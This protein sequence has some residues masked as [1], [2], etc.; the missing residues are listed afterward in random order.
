MKII[1]KESQ[2]KKIF[3][4]GK[5][6]NILEEQLTN[7]ID[8][9]IDGL[10]KVTLVNKYL[11]SGNAA[12]E[13]QTNFPRR[14]IDQLK[15]K[16]SLGSI[17]NIDQ[18]IKEIEN[19]STVDGDTFKLLYKIKEP[20][21]KKSLEKA[22]VKNNE[23]NRILNLYNKAESMG[24]NDIKIEIRKKLKE[25]LGDSDSDLDNFLSKHKG[26]KTDI[27]VL[28]VTDDVLGMKSN[29]EEW[30]KSIKNEEQFLKEIKSIDNKL[31]ELSSGLKLY[32][33]NKYVDFKQIKNNFNDIMKSKGDFEKF[34]RFVEKYKSQLEKT[35]K[36]IELKNPGFFTKLLGL[37]SK[38]SKVSKEILYLI[39]ILVLISVSVLFVYFKF[40]GSDSSK[41]LSE[42]EQEVVTL[43]GNKQITSIRDGDKKIVL[44]PIDLIRN[45]KLLDS[46]KFTI[47]S[48]PSIR[49]GFHSVTLSY[50]SIS[51]NLYK[52]VTFSFN[53][54]DKTMDLVDQ[55][56]IISSEELE[57]ELKSKK[58]IEDLYSILYKMG[59]VDIPKEFTNKSYIGFEKIDDN[60]YKF[61][62]LKDF[63]FVS[64]NSTF[65]FNV[66]TDMNLYMHKVNNKW[67][68][69]TLDN[70]KYIPYKK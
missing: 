68:V 15:N 64:N 65:T 29:V 63:S 5:Y 69:Y 37:L 46:N 3:L 31:D 12:V 50:F 70:G 10:D 48:K 51:G 42:I 2:Y 35:K 67:D 28:D 14:I 27:E 49:K 54:E 32:M 38:G 62:P 60:T 36:T 16:H 47:T 61:K 9:L 30:V 34:S 6:D 53:E 57:D 45:S 43:I 19:I 41:E 40:S 21:F 33:G 18:F 24:R 13:F 23:I 22:F 66:N 39:I 20:I 11:T 26:S 8:D 58:I 7:I 56:K 44:T 25:Y 17:D 52:N 1:I 55:E 4:S 59:D